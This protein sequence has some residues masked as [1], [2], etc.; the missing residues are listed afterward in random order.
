MDGYCDCHACQR[1]SIAWNRRM[2]LGDGA[3]GRGRPCDG[4]AD[5]NRGLIPSI[6]VERLI[7]GRD[8]P[9]A[10][11]C[12]HSASCEDPGADAPISSYR[13]GGTGATGGRLEI[14]DNWAILHRACIGVDVGE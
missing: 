8:R 4:R 14:G 5:H 7:V 1:G 10:A 3:G 2:P 9:P 6:S 12:Q 13:D 11:L